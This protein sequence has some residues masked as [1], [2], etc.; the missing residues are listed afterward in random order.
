MLSDEEARLVSLT[1][2]M[3][4]L[5]FVHWSFSYTCKQGGGAMS[6]YNL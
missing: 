6:Y 3:I 2:E 4:A 5:P 1:K